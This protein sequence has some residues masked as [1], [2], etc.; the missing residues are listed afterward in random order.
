M[1]SCLESVL[2]YHILMSSHVPFHNTCNTPFAHHVPW[3]VPHAIAI[4]HH[5]LL[6][7]HSRSLGYTRASLC[8]VP[9]GAF[10]PGV[11]QIWM[12][13]VKCTGTEAMLSDC[14]F[15]GWGGSVAN[16]SHGDDVGVIC[17]D[18]KYHKQTY[19]HMHAQKH[20][21][22]H[23]RPVNPGVSQCKGQGTA[24]NKAG[25]PTPFVGKGAGYYFILLLG[26]GY[27]FILLKANGIPLL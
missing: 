20:M 27:Y 26:A 15:P 4:H 22:R 25:T 18:G 23:T 2:K 5:L 6:L 3:N 14:M 21:H 17:F 16:C 7:T 11:G 9:W 10:G 13:Q 12:N 24:V 19:T 8:L 1:V